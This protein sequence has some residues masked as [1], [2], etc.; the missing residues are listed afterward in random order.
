M[1]MVKAMQRTTGPIGLNFRAV[2]GEIQNQP[3]VC[4]ALG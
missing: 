3:N 2:L 4:A 1:R